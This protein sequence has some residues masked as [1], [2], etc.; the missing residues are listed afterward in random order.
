MPAGKGAAGRGAGWQ[1]EAAGEAAAP[2]PP[3]GITHHLAP[4]ALLRVDPFQVEATDLRHAF[5]SLRQLAHRLP[6]DAADL[7]TELASWARAWGVTA[8]DRAVS[9]AELVERIVHLW[10]PKPA[11]DVLAGLA[12]WANA[13]S[14]PPPEASMSPPVLLDRFIRGWMQATFNDDLRLLARPGAH[15]EG[16]EPTGETVTT[17]ASATA[18]WHRLPHPAPRRGEG[19]PARGT[20]ARGTPARG[21]TEGGTPERG[22]PERGPS[23]RG[24]LPSGA[25]Q[26]A[27][28][29]PLALFVGGETVWRSA[30]P[31]ARWHRRRL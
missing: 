29:G 14:L 18:S 27:M 26:G 10:L 31:F 1:G 20:P 7:L 9:P 30:A 24:G 22:T 13:W 11:A 25:G 4:L 19:A 2:R 15:V 3:Q 23:E 6:Q 5:P 12:R 28:L 16:F 21:T 17:R 8:P